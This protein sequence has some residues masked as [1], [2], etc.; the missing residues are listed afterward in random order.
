M[1]KKKKKKKNNNNITIILAMAGG[2]LLLVGGVVLVVVLNAQ[3]PT[4]NQQAKGKDKDKELPKDQ[5]KPKF[6]P[7]PK[8][9]KDLISTVARRMEMTDVRNYFKQ[10]GLEFQNHATIN[11]KG[12][13]DYK[14]LGSGFAN[15]PLKEWIEKDWVKVVWSANLNVLPNGASNT[16]LA[17]EADADSQ[18]LRIVLM[19]DT[20]V[21]TMDEIT[22]NNTPKAVG[23]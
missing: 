13:R 10:L 17:W 3:S 4:A 6:E 18:G 23:R 12:P 5:P 16:A 15:L 22:F 19:C 8:K 7:K 20:S 9:G 14:A 1:K 2:G 21:Q 11:G